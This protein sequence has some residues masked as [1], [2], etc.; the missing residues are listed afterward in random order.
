[1]LRDRRNAGKKKFRYAGYINGCINVSNGWKGEY[2]NLT[3]QGYESSGSPYLKKNIIIRWLDRLIS[4]SLP[5]LIRRFFTRYSQYL[6][7]FMFAM[8]L[9]A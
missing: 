6:K 5:I 3:K 8:L 1:M 4:N 9:A 2:I 7:I